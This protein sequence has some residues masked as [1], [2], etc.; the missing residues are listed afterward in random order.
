ME[1]IENHDDDNESYE[2]V[3]EMLASHPEINVLY[4]A[5]GGVAG[6]CRAAVE[7]GRIDTM[8]IFTYDCVPSTKK[9][10][11]DGIITATICQQPYKQGYLPVELL[12]RYL[13]EG[14]SCEEF[15]YTDIDIR[16]KENL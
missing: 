8:R 16:I 13:I 2:K 15:H 7:S 11:D 5:A 12:S 10:L 14:I 4:F 6:G 9:L 3:K 1:T